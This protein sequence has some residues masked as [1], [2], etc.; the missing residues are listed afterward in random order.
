MTT[1]CTSCGSV[2]SKNQVYWD[3]SSSLVIKN[4]VFR[5]GEILCEYCYINSNTVGNHNNEENVDDGYEYDS[6]Y[7]DMEYWS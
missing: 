1:H 7:D 6:F 2:L 3:T 4:E 5:T